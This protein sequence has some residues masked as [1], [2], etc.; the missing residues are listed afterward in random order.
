MMFI[1]TKQ[2]AMDGSIIY[3]GTYALKI[4]GEDYIDRQ[5]LT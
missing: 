1:C 4:D 2:M 5:F 3:P